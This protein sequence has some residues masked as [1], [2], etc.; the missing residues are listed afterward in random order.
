MLFK[1]LILAFRSIKKTGIYSTINIIGLSLGIAVSFLIFFWVTDE[2][3][4][5]KCYANLDNI[6][7]IYE[8]QEF[9][10]GQELFTSCTPFPLSSKLQNDFE[11][12]QTATTFTNMGEF[13]IK[14]DDKEFT[15]GPCLF[16]DNDFINI[17]SVH[18]IAG[19]KDALSNPNNVMVTQDVADTFYPRKDAIGKT[20]L[21]NGELECKIAAIIE[22]PS[23]HSTINY[24]L[25]FPVKLLSNWTDL[26]KWNS[27]WPR[28]TV[29]LTPGTDIKAFENKIVNLCKDNGQDATTLHVFPQKN[30]YLY[31]YSGKQNRVQYIYQFL[32]IAFIIVLIAS[33][34]FVNFSTAISEQRK[35]EIGI[36][37][38]LGASKVTLTNQFLIEKSL[39][40]AISILLSLILTSR[41]LPI[42]SRLANKTITID[43]LQN[44]MLWFMIL[45]VFSLVIFISVAY[46]AIYMSSFSPIHSLQKRKKTHKMSFNF[47]NVLI[48]TQFTLS[49]VLIICSI[50]VSNQLYYINNYDLGYKKDNLVYLHLPAQTGKQHNVLTQSFEKITG[51]VGI[52]QA[53]KLPFY[54]G[55][56]TW[57]FEWENKIPDKKVLISRMQVDRNYFST[58]GIT[59]A[60]GTTYSKTFDNWDSKKNSVP[61]EVI[62]NQEAIRRMGMKDPIGKTFGNE[63][64]KSSIVGVVNDFN[65]EN[66]RNSVEPLLLTPLTED[67][68][69]I[70]LRIRPDNFYQTVNQVKAV[71]SKIEPNNAIQLGFFDQHIE[72][73]YTSEQRISGLFRS[74]SFIAILISCIGLF[75]LSLY[76][77]DLRTKEIGVRK[78]NGAKI[79]E[80]II[81]LNKDFVKWIVIAFIIATPLAWFAMNKWLENFAYKTSLSWW[82]FALSGI[83]A[84]GIALLTVSWQSWQA[85]TKNPV[86]ALRYE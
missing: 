4:F 45:G 78:V 19:D 16:T 22:K 36:R 13:P 75:G 21:V 67:P 25:I 74:F 69:C 81:L 34:N 40:V 79:S 49:I 68:G 37:K 32:A 6:Y 12:V 56:S 47:R 58:M 26:S 86:D 63:N 51:V 73:M 9:S 60:E 43:I 38:T 66:L 70:I 2:L 31:S 29:V 28:T 39:L 27:N 33:I 48:T 46:P 7:T 72:D 20:I 10:E 5:D 18:I 35:P 83:L 30:E 65:F 11:E 84:L 62:L 71:W 59:F 54:G 61:A 53:D 8:H 76:T 24:K 3:N 50:F 23:K 1:H 85:A 42:F 14:G 41:F 52:A 82:I 77:I 15:F 80:V 57:D 17:F 64:W 44:P 55:N